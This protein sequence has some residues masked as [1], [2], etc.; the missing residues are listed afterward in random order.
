MY[1]AFVKYYNISFDI[2]SSNHVLHKVFETLVCRGTHG[3]RPGGRYPFNDSARGSLLI[4]T[5]RFSL[6]L[7]SNIL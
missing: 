2:I 4:V 6:L 5:I 7:N 1:V 3:C